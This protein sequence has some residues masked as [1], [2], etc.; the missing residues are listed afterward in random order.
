MDERM[1]QLVGAFL[2]GMLLPGL[3]FRVVTAVTPSTYSGSQ[4]GA[5]QGAQ[6]AGLPDLSGKTYEIPVLWG[7]RLEVMELDSYLLGVVLAEMPVEFEE[8]ALKAQ[9][10]AART[11]ALQCTWQKEKHPGSAICTDSKCCQAYIS[12]E[13]YVRDGGTQED[14]ARIKAA[15]DDTAGQVLTYDGQL[16]EATYF[17]CSGGRTEDALAVWGTEVPYLQSVVS[18][19][20]EGAE[21]FSNTVTFSAAE[22]AA[23]LG[24]NLQGTPSQWLGTVTR[25]RG[26]GVA[27][28]LLA[29]KSY[30]GTQLRS[31]LSLNSTAFT[32]TADDDSVTVTTSGRGHRVGM[33]QYGADAMAVRGSDYGEILAY[34]Y[35][36]TRID[37][38]GDVE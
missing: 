21:I 27:T 29:G 20:E 35:P 10:V 36:G 34:Y 23:C 14:I 32:M 37:K 18:P 24:R 28:M 2:I 33:S 38:L 25:T 8:E 22:F 3:V 5:V 15:V 12:V 26:G 19:G 7:N 6:N 1:K 11:C 31:L 4:L 13:E 9:A 17:S 16:I 30:T